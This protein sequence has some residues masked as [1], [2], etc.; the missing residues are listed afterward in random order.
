M[1]HATA[2]APRSGR[3][4]RAF[5]LQK[6]G[7]L[8][9]AFLMRTWLAINDPAAYSPRT[10]HQLLNSW[11][12]SHSCNSNKSRTQESSHARSSSDW[13]CNPLQS[14]HAIESSSATSFEAFNRGQCLASDRPSGYGHHLEAC[15]HAARG[16]AC[17]SQ[18]S[19]TSRSKPPRSPRR[20][21]Y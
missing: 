6:P 8:A 2:H 21:H 10:C 12:N 4:V 20:Q 18:C 13:A 11:Y 15:N 19:I 1:P 7:V 16:H 5:G 3:S 9:L 14:R 17:G